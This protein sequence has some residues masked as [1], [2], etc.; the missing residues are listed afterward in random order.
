MLQAIPKRPSTWEWHA[1]AT[2]STSNKAS[3]TTGFLRRNLP[4]GSMAMKEQAYKTLVR[5]M[6]EFAS[7]VWD[8]YMAK[9]TDKLEAVQMKATQWVVNG[10]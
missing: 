9:N 3:G 8:L 4:V 10:H 5:L 6:L 1:P 7:P 2:T